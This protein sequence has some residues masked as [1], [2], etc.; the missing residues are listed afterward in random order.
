LLT[1]RYVASARLAIFN[2]LPD[3]YRLALKT[4]VDL[5]D[6]KPGQSEHQGSGARRRY[7]ELRS[8]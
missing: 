7:L 1:L 3:R 6:G 5:T 4:S 8:P 2:G